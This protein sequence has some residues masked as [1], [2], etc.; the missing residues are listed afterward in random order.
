MHVEAVY[1]KSLLPLHARQMDWAGL[2]ASNLH[3]SMWQL[4]A[5][6]MHVPPCKYYIRAKGW[7]MLLTDCFLDLL[8]TILHEAICLF[9]LF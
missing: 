8:H 9:T 2:Y 6:K 7:Q 5:D 3:P 4:I 1:A